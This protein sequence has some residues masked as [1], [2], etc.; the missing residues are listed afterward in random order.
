MVEFKHVLHGLWRWLQMLNFPVFENLEVT[1]TV[2]SSH[3][4]DVIRT[5]IE[6]ELNS[7]RPAI[8]PTLRKPN[9]TD[10]HGNMFGIPIRVTHR[11]RTA[12]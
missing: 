5:A 9:G 1:I 3:G 6:Q 12:P 4:V 11:G 2:E 8:M 7:D 10:F